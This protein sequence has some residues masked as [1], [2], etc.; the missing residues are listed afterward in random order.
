MHDMSWNGLRI[1]AWGSPG[2]HRSQTA[3][4]VGSDQDL[5]LLTLAQLLREAAT[6]ADDLAL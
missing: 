5:T 4:D 3:S 2:D 1:A 6:A